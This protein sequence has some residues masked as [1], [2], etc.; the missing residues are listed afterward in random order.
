MSQRMI[1]DE[2]WS[3]IAAFLREHPRVYVG[4]EQECRRFLEGVVWI[5]RTG[6]QWR[7][8]PQEYG[9]WNNVYKRFARWC[10][11]GVWADMLEHFAAELDMEYLIIDS[12]VV[13]AH[14]CAAGAPK[15]T[16]TRAPKRSDAVAAALA[17]KST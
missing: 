9:R 1:S 12:T 17:P 13:R 10:D 15:K 3:R 14:P 8:L 2:H 11:H 6:A 16:V 4:N 7:M 5:D